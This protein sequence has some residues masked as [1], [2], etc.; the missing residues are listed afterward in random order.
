MDKLSKLD[1][2]VINTLHELGIAAHLRGYQYIITAVKQVQEHPDSI[3]AMTREFYPAIAD[4]HGA[5]DKAVEAGIR[6]AIFRS[7]ADDETWLRILG[8]TGP[9]SN[10]EFI[11]TL[12][13]AIRIKFAL[14]EVS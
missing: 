8:R 9:M 3:H 5:S 14:E 2:E 13:E 12:S 6:H 11:C 1:I 4:I 7:K 10:S